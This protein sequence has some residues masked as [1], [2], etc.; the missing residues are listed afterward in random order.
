MT[1]YTA[2][3]Q[4]ESLDEDY[5]PLAATNDDLAREQAVEVAKQNPHARV[6]CEFRRGHLVGYINDDGADPVGRAY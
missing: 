3:I 2:V 1:T 5:V 4:Y 6:Y